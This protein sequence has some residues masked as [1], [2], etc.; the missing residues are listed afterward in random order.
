VVVLPANGQASLPIPTALSAPLLSGT[1]EQ[2]DGLHVT[3]SVGTY[4]LVQAKERYQQGMEPELLPISI[5]ERILIAGRAVWFYLGKLCW[6]SGLAFSYARWDINQLNP[7][8]Y[9]WPAAA[10]CLTWCL[11]HWRGKLGRGPVAA[12][13]FFVATLSPMLGFILLSTFAYSFVADHYQ[14]VASLG[15]IILVAAT[16]S[17]MAARHGATG[18][19]VLILLSIAVLGA[20]TWQ[21]R[22]QSSVY[23]SS[24]SIWRDTLAK[25][26]G[27]WLAHNNLGTLLRA[28][29]ENAEAIRHY[30]SALEIERAHPASTSRLRYNLANALRANGDLD[31]AVTQ[32]MRVIEISPSHSQARNNLGNTLSL[33]GKLD[34]AIDCFN[35]LIELAPGYADA[36]YNLANALRVQGLSEE[37]IDHYRKAIALDGRNANAHHY[38]GRLLGEKHPGEAAGHYREAIRLDPDS[39][40]ALMGLAWLYATTQ[41]PAVRDPAEA[42]RFATRANEVTGGD[43]P[44]VLYTLAAAYAAESRFTEA[45]ETAERALVLAEINNA[46]ALVGNLRIQIQRYELNRF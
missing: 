10:L 19:R 21:T 24:E 8:Q 2:D 31:E 35:T 5:I 32:Y 6:P 1:A 41:D 39:S 26:P 20:C 4:S 15:P 22:Q 45:L 40:A 7:I 14:Y 43:D 30:R 36:H 13:V 12:Y 25:N 18:K 44:T 33:Q 42:I 11:W 16:G 23:Q 38:L 34:A 27:S 9:L 28:Q 29:G 3:S 37:A 17:V 46:V